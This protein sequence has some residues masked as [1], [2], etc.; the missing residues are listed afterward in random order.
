[1]IETRNLGKRFGSRVAVDDL[2][3]QVETGE[4][5][6][7][8]GPN[9]A[10]KSTTMKMLTG[11]LPASEGTCA[12]FGQPVDASDM[13]TRRRVGYMS[14]AFS[15]YAEL[16]V[17]QNLVLHARLFHLP[18]DG[19]PAR[20]GEMLRR[21]DLEKVA[22]ELPN[23]LPL[24]IRQR[25]SLAVAV[26][27]KPE[28]LILDEPTSGVDPVARDGFWELMVELS[29]RD[30]VTIFI[31]TH[32]MNEA[33]R[34]D[35]ISLM[36]AGK[37]LASDTPDELV[38]QRG[39]LTLEAT[40]I[41]YL[42]EAAGAAAPAQPAE[43]PAVAEQP[44][45]GQERQAQRERFS[46]LRL[47]SYARREAMELR[48]DPIRLTLALLGTALLMFIIGYGINMDVEDL[49]WAV[50]DRDQ[51]TTSQ[52]YALNI[53]GSR[54]FV[55]HAPITDPDDLDRRLRSGELSLAVEIP[56]NFGRDLKRGSDPA[57]GVW[58]D[59]AMPTRANTVLGYV[60]GL[61]TS[62]LADLS[63]QA[64]GAEAS[65][66][67]STEV[68]YRY[69]P[70][71]ESLKAMVPAVIPL[72]LIMIPAMLTALGVVREKELGSITN[73]Y[74]T[75]VTRLEF[76]VGKQ[77]PYVAMGMINFLLMLVLAIVVFR[78]PLKGSFLALTIGAFLYVV[79][80][81][82]LGLFLSTFM[83]SQIAAVF[84]VAIATMIP[85]IQFS[86]LIH[87]V[88]SLEGAAA[89]IGK[90]YP[91]SHFLVVSRGAFSK[92]LGLSDLWA[93]YLPLAA[94]IVVLTLLSVA[95]LKKQE[96]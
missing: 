15:L 24:G 95:C 4:V 10:G 6:G 86:G 5:L 58:I 92:S 70:D 68:R 23:D 52:A 1:M 90:L 27:H 20:V 3:F 21:F 17:R 34:C 39:L 11:L 26:I 75:P 63:R 81:T 51:T 18:A 57:I 55:E 73:L 85:A 13:A 44:G 91:T 89:W 54:Y 60:Q 2:S 62:Y 59:G 76:L 82:G 33:Q 29:R 41:A 94:S 78:V 9:G 64:G 14:Q 19:I 30:G 66:A 93:Y 16:S 74:V 72:L 88:S 28:I 45:D 38:R 71:V 69:N 49:S 40:F 35:R 32:F 96:D 79:T 77:L 48:R 83:R 7:F 84:G 37:V 87:P 47:F 43:A 42:E 65:A 53:A 61:H 36:H 31:S 50:L 12:L 22:D 67:A 80:S 25:L 8:L 46:P 56:P